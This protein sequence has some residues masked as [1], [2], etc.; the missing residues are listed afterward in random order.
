MSIT[1][2]LAVVAITAGENK[3]NANIPIS[4]SQPPASPTFTIP[5]PIE[6]TDEDPANSAT[7]QRV[8]TMVRPA[9]AVSERPEPNRLASDN[10]AAATEVSTS[11]DA[12]TP[13]SPGGDQTT[14]QQANGPATPVGQ[15]IWWA[16]GGAGLVV[17]FLLCGGNRSPSRGVPEVGSQPDA[18]GPIHI[19][20]RTELTPNHSACLV[21]CGSRFLLVGYAGDRM[22]TLMEISD[23][24]EIELI[25]AQCTPPRPKSTTQALREFFVG[26]PKSTEPPRKPDTDI[27][28]PPLDA[29]LPSKEQAGAF[30][31]QL[32]DV[33]QTILAWKERAGS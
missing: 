19:L 11:P 33:R 30:A 4:V 12:S 15:W 5:K 18:G 22:Q 28:E 9:V 20:Y 27:V 26:A 7:P 25:R 8:D 10:L 14:S 6:E 2:L 32:Q 1:C 29:K 23:P 17:V 21:R 3:A 31:D 13:L 16:M 24:A